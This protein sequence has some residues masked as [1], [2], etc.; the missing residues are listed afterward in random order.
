MHDSYYPLIPAE[1]RIIFS[2]AGLQI[3]GNPQSLENSTVRNRSSGLNLFC[4]YS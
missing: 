4:T 2:V 1:A 3:N